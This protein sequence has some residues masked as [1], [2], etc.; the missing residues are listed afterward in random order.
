MNFVTIE[1]ESSLNG[2]GLR[3]I[4]W[5]TG[6]SHHCKDC[7]NP[8][9]WDKSYGT[10]FVEDV[11]LPILLEG[12]RPDYIN[13]LTISGGDPLFID[14]IV[15]VKNIILSVRKIFGDKKT[16]WLY[17]GY[18]LSDLL[19]EVEINNAYSELSYVYRNCIDILN[20]DESYNLNERYY[21]N[22]EYFRRQDIMT[23]LYNIDVLVDGEFVKEKK[24]EGLRFKGSYNQRI[25]NM[26]DK[27]D[28]LA[29]ELY[30]IKLTSDF[31]NRKN[32]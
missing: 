30:N 5:V 9:T 12:L 15:T 1:K 17:T 2:T 31:L 3:N 26:K 4:L 19:S 7:H 11:N 6:C 22:L 32:K 8:E 13:G 14:N 20:D 18:Q 25:I 16:I 24:I 21:C 29:E 10:P 27:S 28:V 23:I